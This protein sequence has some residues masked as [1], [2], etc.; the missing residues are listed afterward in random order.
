VAPSEFVPLAEE[1][2]AIIPLGAWVLRQACRQLG[3]WRAEFGAAA[4]A[5]VAGNL[6][7][8][9]LGEPDL[10]GLVTSALADAGLTG[11]D[12]C[13]EL[14]ESVLMADAEAAMASLSALRAIGVRLAIDDFG[15]G[16]SSLA[17]LRRFSVETLKVDRS[18]VSGLDRGGED[19]AIVEA[20]VGLARSLG[21]QVVAEGVETE[22][23]LRRL[24]ALGCDYAQGFYLGHPVS[25]ELLTTNM[26][27]KLGRR[28][29]A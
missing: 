8:R 19:A 4:P 9:Q 14:T 29:Q 28:V 22:G 13:L 7:A 3:A 2:G 6:S 10:A 21:L 24:E 12:L 18:F 25:A 27:A 17:Y 15:T 1:T 20:I 16:Y 26:R 23:Q 11:E 5:S